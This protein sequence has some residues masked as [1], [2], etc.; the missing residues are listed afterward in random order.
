M[1]HVWEKFVGGLSKHEEIHAKMKKTKNRTK[2]DATH[3]MWCTSV[4][5]TTRRAN[6]QLLFQA[7]A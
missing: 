3:N 1:W 4:R 6:G 5:S 2:V 7:E